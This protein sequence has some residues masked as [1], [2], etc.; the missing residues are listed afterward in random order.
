MVHLRRGLRPLSPSPAGGRITVCIRAARLLLR[1][2]A[3]AAAPAVAYGY[4]FDAVKF[5]W[6]IPFTVSKTTLVSI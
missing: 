3:M 6:H 5:G 2:H 1:C 4:K